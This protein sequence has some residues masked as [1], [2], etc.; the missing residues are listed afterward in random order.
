MHPDSHKIVDNNDQICYAE[1]VHFQTPECD[2][3]LNHAFH[4]PSPLKDVKDAS[5]LSSS[6]HG[7]VISNLDIK[8]SSK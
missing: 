7:E 1:S 4:L 5:T 6:I 2:S 3:Y 8:S